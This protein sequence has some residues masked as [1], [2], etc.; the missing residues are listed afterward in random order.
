MNLGVRMAVGKIAE[1][2]EKGG[3]VA[4]VF[5]TSKPDE[6]LQ[7]GGSKIQRCAKFAA[8]EKYRRF[9][10]DYLTNTPFWKHPRYLAEEIEPA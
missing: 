7:V 5:C 3:A 6:E 8:L 4:E 1:V 2:Y 10:T 9:F